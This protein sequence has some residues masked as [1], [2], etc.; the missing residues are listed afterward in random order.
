[1]RS[2]ILIPAIAISSTLAGVASVPA[3]VGVADL[4]TDTAGHDLYVSYLVTEAFNDEI[5]EGMSSGIPITFT[6]HLEVARRRAL[7]I[8]KVL[9]RKRVTTTA[10]FDTLTR[11]YSLTRRVD[12]EVTETAV[13]VN[14]ADMIRWMTSLDRI[15]L[16]DPATLAADAGDTLYV[17][18][19]SELQRKFVLFFLPWDVETSWEKVRLSLTPEP[20][21]RAR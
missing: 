13:A 5:R 20:A 9:A 6:H 15:R 8:D 14:E 12:D 4:R 10:T 18:V 3:G 21:V 17:R 16:A 11:Q 1:V 7:W 19:K 2:L